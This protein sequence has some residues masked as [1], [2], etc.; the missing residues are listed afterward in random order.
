[1]IRDDGRKYICADCEDKPTC[2]QLLDE[3]WLSVADKNELLCISCVE[4]RLGF[5]L[6]L[7]HLEKCGL[8]RTITAFVMKERQGLLK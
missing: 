7:D 4:K 2:P 5:G 3:V 8:T 1:M 6:K